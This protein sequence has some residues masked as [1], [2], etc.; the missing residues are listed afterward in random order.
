MEHNA[1]DYSE[2]HIR[3]HCLVYFILILVR[4][5]DL[6]GNGIVQHSIRKM[7]FYTRSP[8]KCFRPLRHKVIKWELNLIFSLLERITTHFQQ[9]GFHSLRLFLG[10]TYIYGVRIDPDTAIRSGGSLHW[11]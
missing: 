4:S 5:R 11:I 1:I 3:E 2:K 7:S 10:I 9:P 6:T 8:T